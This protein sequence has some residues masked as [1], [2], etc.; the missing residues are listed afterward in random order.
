MREKLV[1]IGAGSI[2]FTRGLIADL[3]ERRW[4]AELA[5]VDIDPKILHAAERLC[6]RMVEAHKGKVVISASTDRREVLAGATA[7]I[8]T[9][10][11]GGRRAWEQ[12]VFVPRKHGVFQPVGDTV[13]PG[14]CA[15][16][17]RMIPVMVAIAKD[18]LDLAPTALLVNYSNPM[19]AICR[20]VH[21]A[22]GSNL[23]GLCH[24]VLGTLSYV[25]KA[26]GV[27][28]EELHYTGVG[29]N[30]LTWLIELKHH[31]VDVMPRLHQVAQERAGWKLDPHLAIGFVER[32]KPEYAQPAAGGPYEDCP[33][34]WWLTRQFGAF[35]APK[36]RHVTEFFPQFFRTGAYYGKTLGRDAYSF[37]ETVAWGDRLYAEMQEVAEA[38]GPLP[39]K[40]LK[41]SGGDH[42]QV[43]DIIESIR[44]N[45]GRL[46]SANLPNVGQVPNLP[47]DAVIECPARADESGLRAVHTGPMPGALAGTLATRFAC[48]E[49]TVEAALEGSRDKFVQALVLDGAAS[50]PAV[51]EAMADDLLAAHAAYLPQFKGKQPHIA[52]SAVF[53]R[54]T[55]AV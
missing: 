3:L 40:Y 12:D 21:K 42:E 38:S 50:S 35:P 46:Y 14:G 47:A 13:M 10:A 5:L 25:A 37:E 18:V 2:S 8:C 51:A 44:L 30:H 39:E 45:H 19:S 20:A 34:A 48:V 43:M 1:I 7:V 26:I 53:S 33:F 24:G 49:M 29:I 6:R 16:A 32:G 4:E 22:T 52:A 28:K 27:P 9:I 55:P 41:I 54:P 23:V 17:L 15:R 36:D 31:G 11:V